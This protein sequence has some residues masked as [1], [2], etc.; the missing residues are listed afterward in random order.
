MPSRSPATTVGRLP[1][2]LL[3]DAIESLAEAYSEQHGRIPTHVSH[4]DPSQQL[5]ALLRKQA[6][7][8]ELNDP[9]PYRY[10]YLVQ[11]IPL[12]LEKL[13]FQPAKTRALLTENG[14]T[15]ISLVANWLKL[16]GVFEVILLTPYY[17]TTPYN[18][19]RLGI[20]VRELPSKRPDSYGLP[21]DIKV[22]PGQA[23]WV[24]NPIYSTGLFLRE[25]DIDQLLTIANNGAFVIADEALAPP[26][27]KIAAA[28]CGHRNFVGIYTPHKSICINGLK[29][30]AIIFHPEHQ[31]AFEDWADILSGGLS[32][33]A[34][35]AIDHFLSPAFDNYR[36]LF[37]AIVDETREWHN[38]L[39]TLSGDS[40]QTD[41]YTRGHFV[42]TYAPNLSASLGNNL[43]FLS[44]MLKETGCVLIPGSRS[45]FDPQHGFCFRV[46]LAQDSDEFRSALPGLYKFLSNTTSRIHFKRHHQAQFSPTVSAAEVLASS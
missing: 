24:T 3:I 38:S 34:M 13:G 16:N 23:L 4:W 8:I 43:S 39:V 44:Q 42:T 35:A 12:I 45:G 14:T 1:E 40:V 7:Y 6:P 29:F 26:P 41:H 18:L 11:R 17:F 31:S 2:L 33:S 46:N 19:R 15:C 37:I 27:S 28:L 9:V 20:E 22:G 10:S 25:T 30:S 5:T 32:V 36:A 21:P